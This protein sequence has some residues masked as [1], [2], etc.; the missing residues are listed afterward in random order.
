M[1]HHLNC[2]TMC[3]RAA[4]GLGLVER[5]P[6]HLVA[7]C[8][9]IEDA[10]GLILLDTGFGTRDI[11]MPA[12]LGPARFLI[13]PRL[14]SAETAL[15]QVRALGY[16]PGDVRHILITH[17][18]L[19]HA[20]GLADFPNAEVHVHATELDL[21]RRRP[22][23]AR[24]RYRF[25][26]WDHGPRWVDHAELGE[27]WF[28]FDRVKLIDGLGVD[29][30]MIPLFGHSAGHSG[31]A[32][33]S[34]D[35]WLLHAGDAYLHHGEIASPP[36]STSALRGY[37]ALNSDDRGRRRENAERLAALARDHGDQITVFCS[38]DPTEFRRHSAGLEGG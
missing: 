17:L 29:I 8:L 19:D 32:I 28:G 31:Y 27:P 14:D 33:R 11:A 3:P 18:D 10:A 35:Q 37:H 13:A 21:V 25:G 36:R 24:L 1:I 34:G 38:H 7:H 22:L 5:D 9:L 12:R 6:G 2:G 26:Q 16:D 20:G 4:P 15:A 30:A 23:S